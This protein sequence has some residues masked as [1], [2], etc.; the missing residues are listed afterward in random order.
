MVTVNIA[1]GLKFCH[2]APALSAWT[3]GGPAH[4]L[5]GNKQ[6]CTKTRLFFLG[7]GRDE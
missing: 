6:S 3:T 7:G 5:A 2:G 1:T 4:L